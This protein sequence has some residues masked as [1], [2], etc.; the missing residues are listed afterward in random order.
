MNISQAFA[1]K[2]GASALIIWKKIEKRKKKKKNDL[3]DNLQ[4][5]R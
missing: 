3:E 1:N 2:T 4:L 5:K